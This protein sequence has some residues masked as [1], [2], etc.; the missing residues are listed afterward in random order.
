MIRSPEELKAFEAALLLDPRV[1]PT[2]Q[3]AVKIFEALWI[4]ACNMGAMPPPDPLADLEADLEIAR[5]LNS[6]PPARTDV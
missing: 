3:E 2:P 6:P 1:A 4:Q 5:T